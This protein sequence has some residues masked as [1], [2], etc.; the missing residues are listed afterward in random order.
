MRCQIKGAFP[1][2]QATGSPK[3]VKI[4]MPHRTLSG[5]IKRVTRALDTVPKKTQPNFNLIFLN[6]CIAT[7]NCGKTTRILLSTF[8]KEWSKSEIPCSKLFRLYRKPLKKGRR[9]R[10]R[11]RNLNCPT[12]A[13][14][15]S[16]LDITQVCTL[17]TALQTVAT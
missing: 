9:L 1:W 14:K 3:C 15:G 7:P 13:C 8:A 4:P 16:R 17:N 11:K 10:R 5:S 6:S 2:G 12:S